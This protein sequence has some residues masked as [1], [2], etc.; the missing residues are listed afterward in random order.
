VNQVKYFGIFDNGITWR[1]HIKRVEAKA[2]R[3]F[4]RICSLFK[5]DRLNANLKLTLYKALIRSLMTYAC[6]AWEFAADTHLLKFQHLQ[7]KVLRINGKF[8]RHTLIGDS[9]TAFLVYSY[10]LHREI[11]QA[12]SI[13][14]TKS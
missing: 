9:P 2:C 11:V 7:N 1:L 12:T 6:P 13:G 4:I 8:P 14:H 3:T 5:S 10:L